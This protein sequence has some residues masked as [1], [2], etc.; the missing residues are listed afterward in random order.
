MYNNSVYFILPTQYSYASVYNKSD[1][2]NL[3]FRFFRCRRWPELS[4]RRPLARLL[5]PKIDRTVQSAWNVVLRLD[6][7]LRLDPCGAHWRAS[8]CTL[9]AVRHQTLEHHEKFGI[10]IRDFLILFKIFIS[11]E[12]F[13]FMGYLYE[14]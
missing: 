1:L 10:L 2:R 9:L 4:F 8:V 11:L 3:S 5:G 13:S 12:T 6:Q 7:L 14:I